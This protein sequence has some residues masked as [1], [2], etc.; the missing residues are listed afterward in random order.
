MLCS[1]VTKRDITPCEPLLDVL[2]CWYENW[3]HSLSYCLTFGQ[4]F[5]RSNPYS[6]GFSSSI[7]AGCGAWRPEGTPALAE[8]EP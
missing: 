8:R 7:K 4:F 1:R 6:S 2:G 3:I 5:P